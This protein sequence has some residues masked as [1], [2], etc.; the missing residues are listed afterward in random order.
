MPLDSLEFRISL[1]RLLA[2]LIVILVP[3]TVFGFYIGL[4]ADK[5]VHQMNGAYF[6][7]IARSAAATTSEFIDQRVTEASLI[8]NEPGLVHAV[9]VANRA[10][11]HVSESEIRARADRIE[12]TWNSSESD[13]RVNTMLSSDLSRWLQS[14]VS[15]DKAG[16]LPAPAFQVFHLK[17]EGH[18]GR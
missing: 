12:T 7:T 18:S 2:A 14:I 1:Q 13:S 6:R 4:Q 3:I 5:Q 15:G 10:Y 11:E 9:T 8:A 16:C 17:R